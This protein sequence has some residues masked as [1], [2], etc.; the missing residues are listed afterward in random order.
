MTTAR[1]GWP[2]ALGV[3]L[4]AAVAL[5][6]CAQRSARTG[7]AGRFVQGQPP[8]YEP[9]AKKAKKPPRE[10]LSAF[11]AR[12]RRLSEEAG[13]RPAMAPVVET[14]DPALRDALARLSLEPSAERHVDV[15]R[16]YQRL[17]VTDQALEHVD[18]AV[19]LAPT[20]AAAH[21]LMA[22]LWRDGGFP[23][24]GLGSAWRAVH[25]APASAAVRNTLG[26]VLTALGRY[27]EAREAYLTAVGLDPRAA[28]ARANLCHLAVVEGRRTQAIVACRQ[29]LALEP[30]LTA[31]RLNLERA[32]AAVPPSAEGTASYEPEAVVAAATFAGLA[33]VR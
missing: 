17:K 31:A 20:W 23:Q 5:G 12:V 19:R 9:R 32:V 3:C 1:R 27:A 13:R 14:T 33:S 2:V 29:A 4:A 15:A 16:S 6:G 8:A 22:R 24:Y 30:S 10:S 28:Y 26:T 25:Y 7:M 11:I 21:D 18:A